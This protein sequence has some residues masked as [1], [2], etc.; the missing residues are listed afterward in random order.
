MHDTTQAR[1]ASLGDILPHAPPSVQ[2]LTDAARVT[3]TQPPAR[4]DHPNTSGP[5]TDS[6]GTERETTPPKQRSTNGAPAVHI[7]E[8]RGTS[9]DNNKAATG[10]SAGHGLDREVRPKGLEPLT[11]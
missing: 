11:F 1:T 3:A 6:C 7:M 8:D 2:V 9:W 5:V 10:V 4:V